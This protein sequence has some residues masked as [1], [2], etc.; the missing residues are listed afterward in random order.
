MTTSTAHPL[1]SSSTFRQDTAKAY[2]RLRTAFSVAFSPFGDGG[3][4]KSRALQ[5][6]LGIDVRLAWQVARIVN[7][8]NPLDLSTNIPSQAPLQKAIQAARKQGAP[9]TALDALSDAYSAFEQHIEH[10]AGDRESFDAMMAPLVGGDIDAQLE[11]AHRRAIFEGHRHVWG[12]ELELHVIAN[13]V[14]PS[15]KKNGLVDTAV[16]RFRHNLRHLHSQSPIIVEIKKGLLIEVKKEATSDLVGGGGVLPSRAPLDREAFVKHGVPILPAFCSM[17]DIPMRRID[18]PAGGVAAE[19]LPH[20]VGRPSTVTFAFGDVDEEKPLITW[21]D[22]QRGIGMMCGFV[23]PTRLSVFDLLIHRPTFGTADCELSRYGH[24]SYPL[25]LEQSESHLGL[26]L[27][28][29]PCREQAMFLG[30]ADTAVHLNNVP[31]YG[32]LLRHTCR[33]RGWRIDDFD[34]YRVRSEYPMLDTVMQMKYSFRNVP[35]S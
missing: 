14:H 28:G 6:R 30:S 33:A 12:V 29:L 10:Y 35:Q 1:P 25:L 23:M 34:V 16:V 15:L 9:Q 31:A 2:S 18:L 4:L 8:E 17:P 22:G 11:Q 27:P 5:R 24:A 19:Y 3:P 7:A 26:Q 21:P 32:D 13:I 20:S